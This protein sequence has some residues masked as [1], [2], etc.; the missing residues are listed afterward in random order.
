MATSFTR[1]ANRQLGRSFNNVIRSQQRQLPAVNQKFDDLISGLGGLQKQQNLNALEDASARGVLRSTIPVDAQ[2]NIAQGIVA[3]Q[4][5][6]E[7][8]RLSEIG[9]INT[10]IAQTRLQKATSIADLV[11]ALMDRAFRERQFNQDSK[12]ADRQFRLDQEALNRGIF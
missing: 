11:S 7:G 10:G 3:Q 9:K 6:L 4:G 2:T 8:E 1:Q 5:Q 12:L